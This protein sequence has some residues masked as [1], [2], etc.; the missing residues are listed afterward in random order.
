MDIW[1]R[2]NLS[3]S[4]MIIISGFHSKVWSNLVQPPIAFMSPI[5]KSI[6]PRNIY[7]SRVFNDPFET[8][9]LGCSDNTGHSRCIRVESDWRIVIIEKQFSTCFVVSCLIKCW[10]M[11]GKHPRKWQFKGCLQRQKSCFSSS[12][13]FPWISSIQ[14]L[15][16]VHCRS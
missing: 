3:L 5:S 15:I 2:I 8:G 14:S 1:N 10:E 9:L 4:I 7:I 16:K 13:N 12:F 11:N 6:F